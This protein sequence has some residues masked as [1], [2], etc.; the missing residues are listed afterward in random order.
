MKIRVDPTIDYRAHPERYL[1]GRGEEGVLM[2]QPYKGEILPLWRF[3]TPDQARTSSQAI[4]KKYEA[5]KAS[6]DFVGM[7]MARKYLQ[8]GWTRAR[9]YANHKTGKKYDGPVPLERRGQSGA[10][11]RAQLPIDPDPVKAESAAIFFEL[12]Q[13]V[14]NDPD[15]QA[16]KRD[17]LERH[18]RPKPKT[19]KL[20]KSDQNGTGARRGASDRDKL[21]R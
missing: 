12:Y 21:A 17:H 8:M 7:D 16:K 10:W 3:A 9:R 18:E 15:Y 2:V 1:V 14:L 19:S 4:F 13:R 20:V 6:G 5:Y 11:G